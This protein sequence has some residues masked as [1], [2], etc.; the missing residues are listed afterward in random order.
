MYTEL[1]PEFDGADL[2]GASP[3]E[4]TVTALA[5]SETGAAQ[6]VLPAPASVIPATPVSAWTRNELADDLVETHWVKF[7][8]LSFL[9]ISP[10][11]QG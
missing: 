4:V 7:I 6:A 2:D 11:L 1:V 8:S 9:S 5:V 3:Q 10:P